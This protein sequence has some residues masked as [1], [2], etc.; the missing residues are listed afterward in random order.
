MIMFAVQGF[1]R[2]RYRTVAVARSADFAA[3]LASVAGV[4][5]GATRHR[6]HD[7]V[8]AVSIH[9][10]GKRPAAKAA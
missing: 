8:R 7:G 6:V 3:V 2:N 10:V 9:G 4:V 5:D 1:I